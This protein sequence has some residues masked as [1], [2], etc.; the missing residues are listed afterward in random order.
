[1]AP[2]THPRFSERTNAILAYVLTADTPVTTGG[3]ADH[4]N[5]TNSNVSSYLRRLTEAGLI[6]RIF[7]GV[8]APADTTITMP[9]K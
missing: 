1:M 3:V 8:Y 9:G 2:T 5:T 4:F 7:R 6:R